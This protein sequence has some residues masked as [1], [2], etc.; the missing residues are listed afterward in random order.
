MKTKKAI[1]I[2]LGI[3]YYGLGG[4]GFWF[5]YVFSRLDGVIYEFSEELFV[6]CFVMLPIA[7]LLLPI[8]IR[9]FL[10][11]KFY[12]SVLF[13]MLAAVICLC[14]IFTVKQGILSYMKDFTAEKW[15]HDDYTA[16]RYLMI[17]D[18]EQKHDLLGMDKEEVID[19]L[20]K[21]GDYNQS[22]RY[23]VQNIGMLGTQMYCLSYDENGTIT[24]TYIEY[25]N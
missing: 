11:K 24:S 21:E 16:L 8:V 25:M 2:V 18:L 12:Q 14:V 5:I 23:H 3:L 6:A 17:D 10:R 22:L 9:F 4:I 1:G 7:A 19:I 20:G 13:G 15:N